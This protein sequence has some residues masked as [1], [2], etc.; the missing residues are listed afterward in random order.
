VAFGVKLV[1]LDIM[2]DNTQVPSQAAK[3][4]L[5]ELTKK[6]TESLQ[7]F[8]EEFEED[9]KDFQAM[10]N[11]GGTFKQKLEQISGSFHKGGVEHEPVSRV[12]EKTIEMVEE[13]LTTP[14]LEKK[15]DMAGYIEKV[16]KEAEVP[17]P[18]VDDYTQQVLLK[19][20][21]TQNPKVTLPMTA[22]DAQKG[23]KRAVWDSVRWLATWCIRQFKMLNGRAEYKTSEKQ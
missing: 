9:Q 13:I 2:A 15:P 22:D 21:V 3:Q 23:L 16:E 10:Y 14:E 5:D 20:S 18:I 17:K 6:P 7:D 12:K 4:D 1:V 11:A 19:S 8:V